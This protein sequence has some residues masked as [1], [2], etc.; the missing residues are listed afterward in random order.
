MKK[1]ALITTT[2]IVCFL[3]ALNVTVAFNSEEGLDISLKDIEALAWIEIA[4]GVWIPEPGDNPDDN[5][6]NPEY[7][8]LDWE[9]DDCEYCRQWLKGGNYPLDYSDMCV[10]KGTMIYQQYYCNTSSS[11]TTCTQ[12]DVNS[13]TNGNEFCLEW[14]EWKSW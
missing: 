8:S 7:N 13:S 9:W 14:E 5:N 6:S 2:V 10:Q 3:A 12:E 1:L 4:P 11:A